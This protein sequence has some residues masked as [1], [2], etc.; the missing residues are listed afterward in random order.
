VKVDPYH[1]SVAEYSGERD[2]YHNQT[3]C[4]AGKRIK[5]EHRT[6]GK[7]GRPKCDDCNRIG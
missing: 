1:T 4:P 5:P 2:V 7:A 3:E 6:P